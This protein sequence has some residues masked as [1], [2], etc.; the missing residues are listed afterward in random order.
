MRPTL[1]RILFG[2]TLT[3]TLD[4]RGAVVAYFD[5]SVASSVILDGAT[6]P[7][8]RDLSSNA[9]H[10]GQPTKAAQLT[11]TNINGRPALSS[12]GVDDR[13]LT[14]S[15]VIPQ[16]F[17]RFSVVTRRN[18]SLGSQNILSSRNFGT[19]G[20]LLHN[21]PSNIR[22]SAG[23]ILSGV[24][25]FVEGQT[26]SFGEQ[27]NGGNS[28]FVYNGLENTGDAGTAGID[29][30][31]IGY[32]VSGAAFSQN[33]FHSILILNRLLIAEESLKLAAYF[34]QRWRIPSSVYNPW[35]KYR[36]NLLIN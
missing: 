22:I 34:G 7:E 36:I 15:F 33:D 18:S 3:T 26:G 6:S 19:T 35:A 32:R 11:Y 23:V 28:R 14:E 25:T 27:Y 31:G 10:L 17:S 2:S 8:W 12:D 13:M 29:G 1:Q 30:L 21:T 24:G 4:L 16:P 9:R 5:A 20:I